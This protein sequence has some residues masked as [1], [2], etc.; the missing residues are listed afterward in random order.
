MDE[1][2]VSSTE[3]LYEDYADLKL[4]TPSG[5]APYGLAGIVVNDCDI[6]CGN[7]ATD[8]EL[9]NNDKGAIFGIPSG[10]IQR[11][12]AKTVKNRLT[13]ICSSTSRMTQ[14]CTSACV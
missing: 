5:Y 2:T 4:Q 13:W 14:N 11:Q 6:I 9:A 1:I 8:E 3:A 7:C 10:I 12:C